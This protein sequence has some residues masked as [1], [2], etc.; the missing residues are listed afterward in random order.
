[1]TTLPPGAGRRAVSLGSGASRSRSLGAG[2]TGRGYTIPRPVSEMVGFGEGLPSRGLGITDFILVGN[3]LLQEDGFRLLQ[4]D[5]FLL[6][7]EDAASFGSGT[8]TASGSG[9]GASLVDAAGSGS[10][11]AS[12]SGVLETPGAGVDNLIQ[13][14]GANLLQEDGSLILLETGAVPP[15]GR[16]LDVTSLNA[17][18]SVT[19]DFLIGV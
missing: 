6:S 7:L 5:G 9:V 14:D 4:E 19:G 8:A 1:M 11:V 10:G 16:L 12:G 18:V 17:L 13:E 3:G 2:E 15:S